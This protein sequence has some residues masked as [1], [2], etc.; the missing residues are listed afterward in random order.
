M[1]STNEPPGQ[2][3]RTKMRRLA[4]KDEIRDVLMRY[5]RAVDR[6]DVDLLRSCYH[7]DSYDDHGHF[8]GNGHD[9]AEF[10]VGSLAQRCHATTHAVANVLIELDDED[11]NQALS[12]AYA[13]SH[14]RRS[15]DTGTEWLDMFAGRYVDRFERRDGAWRIAHRVVVHDWSISTPLVDTGFPLPMDTFTQGQRDKT[16]II[17]TSRSG[18]GA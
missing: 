4:D 13:L 6:L 7:P 1:T 14:L 8:K 5:G 9:F 17:Y 2:D 12:E 16:D 11:P 3:F 18:T 15:D 10:I